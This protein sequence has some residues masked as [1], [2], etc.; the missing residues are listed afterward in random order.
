MSA[1]LHAGDTCPQCEDWTLCEEI[2]AMDVD[3]LNMQIES[4]VWCY[5]CHW[6]ITNTWSA[7]ALLEQPALFDEGTDERA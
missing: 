6:S 3:G 7:P 1:Q 4:V 2:V 5:H